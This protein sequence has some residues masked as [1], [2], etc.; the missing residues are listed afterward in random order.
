MHVYTLVKLQPS[1]IVK[2]CSIFMEY[3][4]QYYKK[5]VKSTP[6]R[7]WEFSSWPEIRS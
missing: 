2:A 6:E 5:D 1:L 4:T 7:E 3:L